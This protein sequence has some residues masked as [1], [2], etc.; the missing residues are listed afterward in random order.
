MSTLG[1]QLAAINAPGKNMGSTI[2]TSRRHEDAIGRGFA[3]SVQVG[4]G[5]HNKSHQFKPSIIHEDA[6]KASDV[7][8]AMLRE[9][10]VVSLR[11]LEKID[12]D[13]KVFVGVLCTVDA[14]ERGL[15][16]ATENEEI[17]KRI[18]DLLF[19]ISLVMGDSKSTTTNSVAING[20]NNNDN[21]VHCLHVLEFLLRKYDI[22]VSW[23]C[24]AHK[25]I[26]AGSLMLPLRQTLESSYRVSAD[27]FCMRPSLRCI[28]TKRERQRVA[29]SER[30]AKAEPRISS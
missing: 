10:C 22:P 14:K 11:H 28:F 29:C 3:H 2:S 9:N 24:M 15:L 25:Y 19:R 13:F 16:L 17:D 4:H 20:S 21:L 5:L 23:S 6:K 12:S 27:L 8:L 18:E 30:R 7:P 26:C 1:R